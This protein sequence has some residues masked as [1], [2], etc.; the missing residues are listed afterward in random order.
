M[1]KQ[2]FDFVYY[3]WSEILLGSID[4]QSFCMKAVSGG[5]RGRT[6]GKAEASLASYSP[7]K[8]TIKAQGK[9]GGSLP[10]GL[11]RVERPSE[12]KGKMGKPVAKLT[13]ISDQVSAYP[14]RE[15]KKAPFLIHGRGKEG[16]DGCIV[17][18]K[19]HRKRL[20]DAIEKKGGATLLVSLNLL[21]QNILERTQ[22]LQAFA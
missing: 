3:V 8:T 10:P 1:K 4:G 13:P 20:L 15:Y 7:H 18:E 6:Q 5:G 19:V 12:Y 17:I 22:R 9:R 11:W 21:D 2:S 14:S 16:S